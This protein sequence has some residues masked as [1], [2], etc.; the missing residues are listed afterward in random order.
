[1]DLMKL[2]TQLLS[3]NIGDSNNTDNSELIQ[4]VI[5]KLLG[6]SVDQGIDLSRLIGNLQNSGLADIADS[7]LGDG[8]N[9]TISLSQ[10]E[11]M[12]GSN[13]I[14][15]AATKLG[16]NQKSLL[17]GLQKMMPQ[18]VDKSSSGGSLLDSAGELAGLVGKFLK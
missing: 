3:S 4:S 1:M 9:A 14:Q 12:L 15:Q 6:G 11:S 8:N 7:W 13:E 2:A 10:I 5:G 16:I 18:V 17:L